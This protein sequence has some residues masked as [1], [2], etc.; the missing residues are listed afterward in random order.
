M[1]IAFILSADEITTL[2]S[3]FPDHTRA[4][5]RFINDALPNAGLCDLSSLAGKNLATLT[6]GKLELA[7]V[8]RMAADA[9]ARADSAVNNDGVWD[10]RSP[11]I[12]LRCEEY[13]YND[14]YWKITPVNNEEE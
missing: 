14:G 2:L 8:L 12:C 9:I 3:H 4:G 7:P 11:W 6:D 10:I 1:D 5:E 13:P